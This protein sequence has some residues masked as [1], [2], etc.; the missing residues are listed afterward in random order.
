MAFAQ[1]SPLTDDGIVAN[2]PFLVV[3]GAGQSTP[4]ALAVS[5]VDDIDVKSLPVRLVDGEIIIE[6]PSQ[7]TR[8]DRDCD[9][10]LTVA[11][12]LCALKMA[13][14]LM[15]LDMNMDIDGDGQVTSGDA[16]EILQRIP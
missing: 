1:T 7:G 6:D 14:D 5:D 12:A 4:L 15:P 16:R 3:D 9:G 8:G 2:L 11:D 13:V 10:E